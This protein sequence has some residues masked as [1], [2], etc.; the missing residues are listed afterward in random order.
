MILTFWIK[1]CFN[2]QCEWGISDKK[3]SALRNS[4]YELKALIIDEISMVSNLQLLYIHLGL[5]EI[6]G[7]SN[8]IPFAE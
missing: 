3:R 5:V 8:N 6:F 7:C 2:D 4:L 1:T